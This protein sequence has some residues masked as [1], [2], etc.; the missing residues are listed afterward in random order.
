MSGYARFA[1]AVALGIGIPSLP[2]FLQSPARALSKV[3]L[4]YSQL[5]QQPFPEA[6]SGGPAPSCFNDI[7]ISFKDVDDL[8]FFLV[9]ATSALLVIGSFLF[10]A[11]CSAG[12]IIGGRSVPRREEGQDG[13]V[14][15]AARALAD[16]GLVVHRHRA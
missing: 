13:A 14:G 7:V 9:K 11:G 1:A 15:G 8:E 6:A 4:A 12:Y 16:R 5:E 3:L 2:Q 10:C